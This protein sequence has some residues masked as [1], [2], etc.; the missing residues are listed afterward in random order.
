MFAAKRQ[1]LKL[2]NLMTQKE[3]KSRL[4]FIFEEFNNPNNIKTYASTKKQIK[5]QRTQYLYWY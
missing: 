1:M 2:G 3:H 5:F 4:L